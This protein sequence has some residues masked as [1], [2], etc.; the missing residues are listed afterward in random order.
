MLDS[1]LEIVLS[2]VVYSE[3][4]WFVFILE[5]SMER[6]SWLLLLLLLLAAVAVLELEVVAADV[7]DAD[8]GG[9][10]TDPELPTAA[11]FEFELFADDDDGVSC[12]L[13]KQ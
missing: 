1:S 4:V 8:M 10:T 11:E 9:V 3:F 7:A 6:G 12:G 5:S 13:P 2:A